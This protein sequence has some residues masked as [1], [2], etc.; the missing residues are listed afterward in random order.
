LRFTGVA[1]PLKWWRIFRREV[2]LFA[3][4]RPRVRWLNSFGGFCAPVE[5]VARFSPRGFFV[6]GRSPAGAKTVESLFVRLRARGAAASTV[7]FLIEDE[8]A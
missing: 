4:I 1:L 5:V 2:F 8:G 6:C 7:M 3:G